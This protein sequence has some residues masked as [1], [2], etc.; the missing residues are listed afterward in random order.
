MKNFFY[1]DG[2]TVSVD[3]IIWNNEG[4]N[5]RKV[6]EIITDDNKNIYDLD[7]SGFFWSRY[8]GHRDL[9][10]LGYE[11]KNNFH[12]EGVAKLSMVELLCIKILFRLLGEHLGLEIWDNRN[13]LYYPVLH[14]EQQKD[15]T[16]HWVWYLYFQPYSPPITTFDEEECYRFDENSFTFERMDRATQDRVRGL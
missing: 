5:V 15:G 11:S 3:D 2:T 6:T 13:Y 9:G 16:Y 1:P 12:S 10:T 7:E 4:L 14:P 8:I